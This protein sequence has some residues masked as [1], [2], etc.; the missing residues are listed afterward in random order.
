M[1]EIHPA[2][3]AAAEILERF[4]RADAPAERPKI[5]EWEA[6]Y[7]KLFTQMNDLLRAKVNPQPD[8]SEACREAEE[9]EA[10]LAVKHYE[11]EENAIIK[12]EGGYVEIVGGREEAEEFLRAAQKAFSK[13]TQSVDELIKAVEG[14]LP[15]PFCGFRAIAPQE[16]DSPECS[17][18]CGN[19]DCTASVGDFIKADYAIK[20]WNTRQTTPAPTPASEGDVERVAWAIALA[21]GK[22]NPNHFL[23]GMKMA[24]STDHYYTLAKAAIAAYNSKP[25][26]EGKL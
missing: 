16:S 10:R 8:D 24:V 15:C 9:W 3:Q 23:A 22:R 11:G 19:P 14:L 18:V 13:P 6:C 4:L 12:Y 5:E 26:G 7:A 2:L 1:S 21:D 25:D 20:M 17:V